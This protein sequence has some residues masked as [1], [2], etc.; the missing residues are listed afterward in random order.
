MMTDRNGHRRRNARNGARG[1]GFTHWAAVVCAAVLVAAV[2]GPHAPAMAQADTDDRDALLKKLEESQGRLADQ[3][4]RESRISSSMEALRKERER[5]NESLVSQAQKIQNIERQM[6][7]IE[8]RLGELGVQEQL[9]RGTLSTQNARISKLLA[10]MQRM[11]RNPPPVIVTR[12][13]DALEM[14]RSAMLLARA[15]PELQD[16]ATR[17]K[18]QLTALNRVKTEINTERDRLRDETQKLTTAQD[19]L[20]VSLQ[21]KKR[22][23]AD[24]ENQLAAVRTE[25]K[26]LA[27]TVQNLN[28]LIASLDTAVAKRTKLG[29]FN[30]E[31]R[32]EARSPAAAPRG[33][34]PA[35]GNAEI[36]QQPAR[37]WLPAP[38]AAPTRDGTGTQVAALPR[39]E[40]PARPA[41]TGPRTALRPQGGFDNMRADRLQP[42]IRFASAKGRLRLPAAGRTI[43]T[44]GEKTEVGR[45]SKGMVI[46]TRHAA[47]ITSPSD[48]WVVFAG[49]FRSFGQLLIINA[50]DDYHILL[51]GLSRIDVQLGQFVLASEPV[52]AMAPVQNPARDLDSS[53]QRPL[54]YVE[55]R[56]KG[57]PIDPDPW[58]SK[59]AQIAQ[60]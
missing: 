9:L 31:G 17:L 48:G 15:F 44:Y 33:D 58:W 22:L 39:P 37:P 25:A 14:V 51:A 8:D 45:R 57:E 1:V 4:D 32:N 42:A 16:E 10:A 21:E 34:V 53:D 49:P 5:L 2:C 59:G 20:Q 35:P 41:I 3:Q 6:T 52:G 46:Q 12:R 23:L 29:A 50:G 60:R 43:L 54:L 55:F 28:E 11:G 7:S 36:A 24:Q 30:A 38:G 47:Q 26:R 27:G 40:A 13:K 18:E 56:H 19:A